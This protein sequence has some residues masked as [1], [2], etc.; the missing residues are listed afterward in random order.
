MTTPWPYLLCA[1]ALLAWPSRPSRWPTTPSPSPPFPAT[2]WRTLRWLIAPALALPLSGPGGA[3]ATGLLTIVARQEWLTHRRA[4]TDL[5]DAGHAATALRTMVAELRA[6]A[7][8][9]T[10]AEAAADAVPAF[11]A[12]L[13]AL[14]ASARFDGPLTAPSLPELAA[15]WT[16]ARRHGLPMADILD[17]TRRDVEAG[18]AFGRRMRAKLAGPK[19]SAAVL[20]GL[21]AACLALGEAM[22]ASPLRILT[23]TVAGQAFLAAG[24]ALV[25]GGATWSR[26]LTTRARFR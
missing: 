17:T 5:T 21:P 13:R 12:D 6:G 23:S 19:A 4:A 24:S 25:W 16:L 1:V 26:N 9:V 3:V 8:P 15:A 11:S 22:G 10:A 14:A 7:H 20:T 18:I 2:A